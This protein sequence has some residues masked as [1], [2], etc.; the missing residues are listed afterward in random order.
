M[1]GV[2][3]GVGKVAVEIPRELAERMAEG[4]VVLFAGAGMSQP[5]LPGW[6]GLLELMIEWTRE[7]QIS[8]DGMEES[9]L[10]LIGQGDVL[11]AAQEL[12][13]RM[14]ESNFFQF[15]QEVFRA[16]GIKPQAA[17]RLVPE[18]GFS[19]VLTGN[20][21]ALIESA[22]PSRTRFY[23]Q[24]DYPGLADVSRDQF[25]IVKV[26]GDV[27]RV[28]SIVLGQ[29][30][31]R[32]VMFGNHAFRVFLIAT[33]TTKTVVFVG[34]SLTDPD[35]LAF[36]DELSF[37][38]GG[39]LGGAHF[40]LMKT[41]GMN[42]LK[43]SNFERRY[44]IRIL[45]DDRRD[46]HPD[47]AGFLGRLKAAPL[48]G[49]LDEPSDWKVLEAETQ[50]I[51]RLLEAMGQR[52]LDQ[53]SSGGYHYFRC[54]YKAGAQTR[55]V[56]TCYSPQTARAAD[57]KALRRAVRAYGCEE[58]ILLTPGRVPRD[59]A[60]AA[61]PHGI[62]AYGRDEFIDNLADFDPYLSKLR[63]DYESSTIEQL[64]VPMKIRQERGSETQG[65]RVHLLDTFVDEWLA[66][67]QRN[68]LSLLGDFGTGKTWFSRRLAW[69]LA[70]KAGGRIPI[71]IA[72]RD[73]S[74]A[75][76]IEQVLTDA[77]SNRFDVKL[78][79]GFKTIRR[80][81]DE[82]RLLLIFD[83]FDEMERRASDYRTA[84]DNFWEIAK[85]I[86]PRAKILLTCRTAFFRHRTEEDEV[87]K[88][89]QG[90]ATLVK[91]ADVIDLR[92]HR[93][94]EVAH[95]TEFDDGQIQEALRRLAPDNW[96]ALLQKIHAL[97]G[98]EDLAHRPVLLRM[99]AETLPRISKD[100][101]LN[102]ATLYQHYTDELLRLRVESIPAEERQ[103]FVEELA[104]EMQNTNRLNVPFSEFPEKVT[105]HFKLKDDAVKAAFFER[106]IRTQS[107]LVR[108]DAGNYRF[109][110]KSMMEYFVARK[111]AQLLREDKAAD[112]PL[113]D[114]IAS[115]VHYLLAGSYK[116]ECCVDGD[117]VYVPPG[118]FIFGW[119]S[120]TNLR[121]AVLEAGFW[122]D[123]YPVT[124]QQFCRFLKEK[125]NRKE[126][127]VEW[128]D[129]EQGRIK[130]KKRE[131]V[132]ERG[133]E[134][135]PVAGVSWYGAAAYAAW[136]GKRLPTEQEWEKAAR[137]VDGRLYPWGEEFAAERCNTEESGIRDTTPVGQY[138]DSGRSVYGCEDMVG[139]VWEWID[140]RREQGSEDRVLRGGGWFIN[141]ENAACAYRNYNDP[142]SR[143]KNVGFRCARS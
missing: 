114:A 19:A 115:I 111:L 129:H 74:R 4:R 20:Y 44:G 67:A 119:E 9:I 52:I 58:G 82:G 33:F 96:E 49:R 78:G 85:L 105:A 60:E 118:P 107:Y 109:A 35:V 28:E 117:T 72:L 42:A 110:H 95:L 51:E 88:R 128:L 120:Q 68:H 21:D 91:G 135:H 125:G 40:A 71:A 65:D 47:I 55:R 11:L 7:Q 46:E 140:S 136:A 41:Q 112:C 48:W 106:D 138:G 86:A 76:D 89:G 103:Y 101:D 73:Y 69:R 116:Y 137:G 97:K 123:R 122:M 134:R 26:H 142:P 141:R 6:K 5:Q 75:Y 22:F 62:Q 30:D 83:G 15:I 32:K 126:G 61:R 38:L 23:T 3:Y 13:S 77:L 64:F 25:A 18:V 100:Q 43:R 132:V 50:D 31:Y 104:W 56:V 143:S 29:A 59:V 37:Q 87:L 84:L 108:D 17:H 102:L 133:Y 8:L 1:L 93:K 70:S 121:V 98:I 16:P 36:L 79:A 63:Y 81:N 45:G 66:S 54:T 139:N 131:F 99:I 127:G 2:W 39:Y 92:D 113:T 80:L 94:F 124:N 24:L 130:K 34:C 12:R 53:R 90:E 10:E 27:D 57:L 14:G